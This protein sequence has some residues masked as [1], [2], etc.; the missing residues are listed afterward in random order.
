MRIFAVDD[1]FAVRLFL[2]KA[3]EFRGHEFAS[4][5][6]GEDALTRWRGHE[7]DVILLD[8][9]MPGMDGIE[10]AEQLRA[11]GFHGP[12]LLF[13][14]YMTPE[15][16]ERAREAGLVAISKIDTEALFRVIATMTDAIVPIAH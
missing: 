10:T 9:I 1:D 6:S 7:P 14:G 13:S 8:L 3:L 12:M 5:A 11:Q 4:A 16:A 2:R 15:V